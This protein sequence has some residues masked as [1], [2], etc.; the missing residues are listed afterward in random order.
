[1][2]GTMEIHLWKTVSKVVARLSPTSYAVCV[3]VCVAGYTLYISPFCVS[4]TKYL[5][6]AIGK[7]VYL[8]GGYN[9][10]SILARVPWLFLT[11]QRNGEGSDHV[12]KGPSEWDNHTLKP[13][14]TMST[15]SRDQR[16]FLHED[17][18]PMTELP[19][20][21]FHLLLFFCC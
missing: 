10:A 19:Y 16:L 6:L 3:C 15:R 1:M 18:A 7:E 4:I 11:W 2:L 12:Q 13:P 21:R 20:T 8:T 17:G 9:G 5:R 14:A